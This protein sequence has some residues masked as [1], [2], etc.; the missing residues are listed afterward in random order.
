MYKCA[1]PENIHT[2]PWKVNGIPRGR[3]VA[4]AKAFKEKYR[5]KLEFLEGWGRGCTPKK[6]YVGDIFWKHTRKMIL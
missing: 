2:S 6:L 3:G 1:V 5:A 4:K